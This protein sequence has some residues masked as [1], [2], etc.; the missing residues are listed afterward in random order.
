MKEVQSQTSQVV[1]S[2]NPSKKRVHFEEIITPIAPANSFTS[3]SLPLISEKPGVRFQLSILFLAL[4]LA[5][6][7]GFILSLLLVSQ[8]LQ[9]SNRP[10]FPG[11]YFPPSPVEQIAHANFQSFGHLPLSSLSQLDFSRDVCDDF[12][13]FV[14]QKW[15]NTHPLSSHDA[16]RTWLTEQSHEIREKFAEKLFDLSVIESMK[17]ETIV[18]DWDV[19]DL[20]NSTPMNNE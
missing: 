13:Q 4:F 6:L 16:K 2:E 9:Q 18:M 3:L 20:S 15:L 11:K 5:L 17:N 10:I 12:Y 19:E 14:C 8:L 7:L 1:F